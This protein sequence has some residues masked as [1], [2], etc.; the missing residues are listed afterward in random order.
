MKSSGWDIFLFFLYLLVTKARI[1][2]QKTVMNKKHLIFAAFI[3]I[4][5]IT[6]SQVFNFKYHV[7]GKTDEEL[8]GQASL[9]DM[10]KD[11]DLDFVVGSSGFSV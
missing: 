7:I 8:L 2:T 1:L 10:D 6:F 11:K 9:V 4:N 5:G 3:F